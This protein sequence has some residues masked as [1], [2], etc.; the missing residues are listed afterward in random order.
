MSRSRGARIPFKPSRAQLEAAAYKRLPD[1]I[2]PGLD[3]LFCGINPGLY[4]AAVGCHFG[5]PGNRFWPTLHRAGFT[6][7]DIWDIASV[8]A[9]YNMTN[10][11]AS[12][13]DMRPNSVYHGQ[14]R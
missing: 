2:A 13:T 1:L 8:A 4:S 11:L 10:R 5:R 6:D 3:V 9:F 12:A 14:A 7:R